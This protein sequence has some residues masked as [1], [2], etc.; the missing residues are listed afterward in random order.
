MDTLMVLLGTAG[1]NFRIAV[2]G[3]NDV[4]L[5][6]RSLSHHDVCALR[7][8]LHPRP[9]QEFETWLQQM[10]VQDDAGRLIEH[11]GP[12]RRLLDA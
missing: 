5:N 1:V 6:C 9:A 8:L 4:M 2:R 3:A 10:G 12:M 11:A 7:Q